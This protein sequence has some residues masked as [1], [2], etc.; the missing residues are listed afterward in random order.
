VTPDQAF[1]EVLREL[2]VDRNLSQERLALDCGL[3]RTFIS[4]LER[5]IRQPTISTL[6][7]LAKG[8][9]ISASELV[10]RVERDMEGKKGPKRKKG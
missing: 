8:L 4:M 9:D 1:G 3:D 6:F 7:K 5:G 10:V 2:R